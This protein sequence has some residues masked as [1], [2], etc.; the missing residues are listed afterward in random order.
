MNACLT[1]IRRSRTDPCSRWRVTL[2]PPSGLLMLMVSSSLFFLVHSCPGTMS[3]T[4]STISFLVSHVILDS[5][6]SSLDLL[7]RRRGPD[8]RPGRK[9]RTTA[10]IA[11]D[12][13]LEEERKQDGDDQSGSLMMPTSS[14]ASSSR[15][16]IRS[17]T[18]S[19][20]GSEARMSLP[21][22]VGQSSSRSTHDTASTTDIKEERL[23]NHVV[24]T[25][26]AVAYDAHA[27]RPSS[28][29]DADDGGFVPS[30]PSHNGSGVASYWA[31]ATFPTQQAAPASHHHFPQHQP[32]NFSTFNSPP[33]ALTPSGYPQQRPMHLSNV[34]PSQQRLDRAD[35]N[36]Y[37]F[38]SQ[39][40]AYFPTSNSAYQ[41]TPLT[42]LPSHSSSNSNPVSGAHRLPIREIPTSYYNPSRQQR[43][44]IQQAPA[45]QHDLYT[46]QSS[47]SVRPVSYAAQPRYL[48][49]PNAPSSLS[50][51]ANMPST[52]PATF[53]ALSPASSSSSTSYLPLQQHTV[54]QSSSLPSSSLYGHS[55]AQSAL[56]TSR[57]P[58]APS[59]HRSGQS[60]DDE[61]GLTLVRSNVSELGKGKRKA[62]DVFDIGYASGLMGN[63]EDAVQSET[64]VEGF[65]NDQ[66]AYTSSEEH[67]DEGDTWLPNGAVSMGQR[68]GIDVS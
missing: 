37:P 23:D 6:L 35:P 53:F 44:Q 15:R 65:A 9:R 29:E 48:S 33:Y 67:V 28:G 49:M 5:K 41:P 3:C 39:H 19:V 56:I 26:E 46:Q 51:D 43:T 42:G 63:F 16:R 14:V 4:S 52:A 1:I 34:H 21:S 24:F 13:A 47:A 8:K 64:G 27:R 45:H 60:H 50:A 20:P 62:S 68:L 18:K 31:N 61:E 54:F 59:H 22:S 36:F 2:R 10:D 32:S 7:R 38:S 66:I 12:R 11:R 58:Q 40:P 55:Q 30:E 57:S 17:A 25:E